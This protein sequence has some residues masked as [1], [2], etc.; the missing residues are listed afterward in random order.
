MRCNRN[1]G[2]V[3]SVFLKIFIITARVHKGKHS[4]QNANLN[5]QMTMQ[6]ELFRDILCSVL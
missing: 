3:I 2:N 6:H 1:V 5:D 4:L